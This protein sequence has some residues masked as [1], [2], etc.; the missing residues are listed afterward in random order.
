MSEPIKATGNQVKAEAVKDMA[1]ARHCTDEASVTCKRYCRF[2][3]M[4]KRKCSRDINFNVRHKSVAMLSGKGFQGCWVK[5]NR[6]LS[7]FANQ[8]P[9]R[10]SRSS[11]K[12]DI[13]NVQIGQWATMLMSSNSFSNKSSPTLNATDDPEGRLRRLTDR[14]ETEGERL[15]AHTLNRKNKFLYDRSLPPRMLSTVHAPLSW[16]IQSKNASVLFQTSQ[17]FIKHAHY[18]YHRWPTAYLLVSLSRLSPLLGPRA[19][20]YWVRRNSSLSWLSRYH[21]AHRSSYNFLIHAP[22]EEDATMC[23]A[24]P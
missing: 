4:K 1:Q 6:V 17:C 3:L 10:S 8:E 18:D 14:M 12:A 19:Y 21:L 24:L 5:E 22:R 16:G 11:W 15:R 9:A 2:L 7:V 13:W 23:P 20:A